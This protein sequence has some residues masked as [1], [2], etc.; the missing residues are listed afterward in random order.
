MKDGDITVRDDEPDWV[1][2][3]KARFAMAEELA[4]CLY[5]ASERVDPGGCE[6]DG[7]WA[8]LADYHRSFYLEIAILVLSKTEVLQRAAAFSNDYRIAGSAES[9]K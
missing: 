2:S 1:S 7:T 3:E 5:E 9:A 8:G 6:G 4:G